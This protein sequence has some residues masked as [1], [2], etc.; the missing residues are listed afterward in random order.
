MASNLKS[1]RQA[2]EAELTHAKKGIA[3]YTARVEALENALHQ[4]ENVEG[5]ESS[6]A[7]KRR[8]KNRMVEAGSRRKASRA[9][10]NNKN[11][12][13]NESAA[14]GRRRAVTKR[15][16]S[17]RVTSRPRKASALP[18]T[19]SEF[20]LSLVNEQPRS[21]VDIANAAIDALGIQPD[22][23]EQIQKMKQRVSPALAGLVASQKIKD[24]GAGRERRF[25]L[26]ESRASQ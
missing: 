17:Q 13:D 23:A 3:Y 4:L 19:G 22:Q 16:A 7:M 25:F 1:A 5:E 8:T 15:S 11:Q 10:Q 14:S 12:D 24:S 18:Q 21:A 9:A 20:W 26:S 2:I 6:A